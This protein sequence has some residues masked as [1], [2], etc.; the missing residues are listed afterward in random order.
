MRD[1]PHH[2]RREIAQRLFA[3]TRALPTSATSRIG[4]TALAALRSG[5]YVWSHGPSKNQA[6]ET[7]EEFDVE[8]LAELVMSI[9]QLKGVAMKMG[10]ILSYIDV[11]VPDS[12]RQAF[13]ALQDHAPPMTEVQVRTILSQELG[14]RAAEVLAG[15][16][17]QPLAAASIG[18]VHRVVLG[19]G[20]ELAIKVQYPEIE[21]AIRSDFKAAA[22]GTQLPSLLLP[23][24]NIQGF[25]AEARARFLEECDYV[26]EAQAQQEFGVLFA[27]HDLLVVPAIFPEL[28][29]RRVLASALVRGQHFDAFLASDPS[30]E[31]RDRIGVALFDFYLGT[32]FKNGLYNCDPHPGNYLFLD[33]NR[34]A[35]LDYGCTRRFDPSFVRK[36]AALTRAVQEDGREALH[37]ALVDLGIVRAKKRYDE[38]T[39][40][41]LLRAFFGPMLHD[42]TA[43]IALDEVRSMRQ[44]VDAKRQ[45]LK[46]SLPAEFLFL[47]R[48]RFGLMSV[49]ARLGAR[50]NWYQLERQAIEASSA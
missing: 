27:D 32:L 47:F 11:A 46:L 44:V 41:R 42:R 43:A 24:V 15:L 40:R 19:D 30:P 48:I 1:D 23:G 9:G 12:L 45:M 5:H 2:L 21:H 10:Q 7:Q 20:T 49:L 34:V 18:Q 26:H 38:A 17:P 33:D 29:T 39:V 3:A 28:C 14:S 4:R 25:V 22:V 35:M 31:L 13:A 6:D 37:A 50:A 8:A 36:M 16:D